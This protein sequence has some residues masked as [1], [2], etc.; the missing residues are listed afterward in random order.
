MIMSMTRWKLYVVKD[1]GMEIPHWEA[2]SRERCRKEARILRAQSAGRK[3]RLRI[4]KATD[5]IMT[6]P[7][8]S[9]DLEV[10]PE[11]SIVR[12]QPLTRAGRDWFEENVSVPPYARLGAAVCVETRYAGPIIQG[13]QADGLRI[14]VYS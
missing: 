13:A 2:D 14:G 8:P 5:P 7:T 3:L 6:P 9:V 10:R 11:G 1:D 12:F 4:R